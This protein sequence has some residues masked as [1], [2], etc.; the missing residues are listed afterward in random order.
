[1]RQRCQGFNMDHT[2]RGRDREERERE[3]GYREGERER[4]RDAGRR[5]ERG[6]S[7]TN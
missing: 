3:G 1:M 7:L 5:G 2:E 4:R 6:V